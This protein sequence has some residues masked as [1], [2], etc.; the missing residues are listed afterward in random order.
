MLF[1]VYHRNAFPLFLS[2][3]LPPF[4]RPLI[5]SLY[6]SLCHCHPFHVHSLFPSISPNVTATLSTSTHYFPLFLP[7][8]LPPFPRP[9]I[10]S[11]YF[12][13][14]HCHPFHVHSLF[15]SISPYV[16]ATLSTSTHY[17]PLFL[18]MSLPPFP[19]PLIISL[20]FSL[21]HCH[22]FHVHSLFPS[23]SP[24]VTAT[25]STSTHYFPLFLPMSLPPFPHPLSISSISPYVTATLSTSTHY[26]PLF[27]PMSLPPFPRPLIISL[28]FSLCHCHP[29]H[30]HSLF[31]SI[32]PYVTATLSTSTH[33]FP[34]FLPMSLPPFPRPLI[35]SLYFSLCH[36]HPFHIHSLFPSISL[37]VTATLSTST[38]Y[39]PLF[40]PMSLPPFPRPLIISLY[41]SLC[42]CHPFHVHSLFPSISPYVTATLSTSTHYFPL[43]LPMSLPPFPRPLII[44]LY[45]SLCHCHPFHVHSLFPSI[46]PYVTATLS[47]STHYFPLFLP[48]SLPPFPRPLIISLYFSLCHCHPFHIHS[49]FPL[50]LPMSLPPFPR[51]LIISLYFS[52]CHCHPFH[53]HSLFP[54]ISLYV[55]ATLSTSTHYFP[56]FLPMSLPPFPRPLIISLYFSLCHCHP[57]HVHSLFPSISPY[58]TATLSTSTHYFPLFL[59]MSLPP[60]P[61]PLIISLYFSQCHC[62]PF[63][64]HSLFPSISLYVTAT[65]STSTH[66]FPLFLPMSLPPFPRPLIISLYFSLC[67]CHPFHV[68]SLFPS[69]SPYVTATLSTSTHYF[70]LFLPMSLPPFPRP[71]IISLYF[72]LCHCHPFHVH[73]LFP[74]ISPY[75]TATL[76]TSTHYFPLFLP[77]SLPPFP[78][79]L[80]ISL[81][82]SLCHCHPFHVHSLFPSISPYVTATLSTSTHYFPLFLPMSL[83]PFPRPLIISLYFS[84]CHC[85]HFHVHSLFPSISPYVTAT[86][87]TSTHYFPLFLPMSLPPFPRPLIISLYFSLCHCHPFHVH[88]LFPSISPYVTATL[89]TSTHYFPLF[90]PMSLPPFPRPLIIANFR[91][92]SLAQ[93]ATVCPSH[94]TYMFFQ[95]QNY[96]IVFSP[97]DSNRASPARTT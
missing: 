24:N 2:M 1:P 4:P 16:T 86:L 27:L 10:I 31:P 51:P 35:I 22:P 84:L 97:A 30:V 48:L 90:L 75:V 56:L 7:M 8:S 38:H 47:T 29:F 9:L 68:H 40:L 52:L 34:L 64:V 61:R 78:R 41:F 20:Y 32:S 89:S 69:I 54:S 11:L 12:S 65:L 74:S 94:L 21:C 79:P 5:I 18:S 43:F 26:F 87:S 53:V 42:H 37:Y 71:L 44:S 28:Y 83:P 6:F 80:I 45:F 50:F 72:S 3:S 92:F 57:F 85:H 25:L 19:R 39:F 77:M 46:S 17:F 82:F 33:Y 91:V 67:H 95:H 60:F 63:H 70:P 59:P 58:V 88:S 13:Q 66:Y 55:T 93:S 73:S 23:I 81:Y 96:C 49:V 76:S 15:P 14:C 62:H 36:C